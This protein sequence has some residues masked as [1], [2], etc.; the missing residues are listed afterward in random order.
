MPFLFNNPSAQ[1]RFQPM[2]LKFS[3]TDLTG[4]IFFLGISPSPFFQKDLD[5]LLFIFGFSWGKWWGKGMPRLHSVHC[6]EALKSRNIFCWRFTSYQFSN[7][8]MRVSIQAL[9][10]RNQDKMWSSVDY[11]GHFFSACFI[12][13]FKSFFRTWI[14]CKNCIDSY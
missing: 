9:S 4:C 7:F 12:I 14:S 8:P 11:V 3:L 6:T 10:M 2:T 1:M 5:W 13:Y